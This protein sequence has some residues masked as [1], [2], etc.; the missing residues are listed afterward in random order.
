MNHTAFYNYNGIVRRADNIEKKLKAIDKLLTGL[1]EGELICAKNQGRYKWYIKNSIKSVYLPKC[2]YELARKLALKKYYVARKQDLLNE[3]SAC[4]RY[5]RIA[6]NNY[7]G[8]DKVLQNAEY[9]R[10]INKESIPVQQELI[11]WMNEDFD[12]NCYHDENLIVKASQGK[13]VRSKSEAIIDRILF[14]AGV[15]FRYE[16]RL[17]LAEVSLYPDFTIRHP[18]TG[19]YYYWEH[20]GM[21]DN[22]EYVSGACRKI[23]QY[24]DNGIIPS[25]N[26]ILTY[27][28]KEHPLVIDEVERLIEVY[29]G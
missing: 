10:L 24:C 18:K 20:F 23:K 11:D 15:P 25:V 7:S 28:T 14:R 1:P 9:A 6:E 12:S 22:A 2:N 19:E 4:R 26:L 21:M 3:L 16:C 27:E 13:Y 17:E 29:F 5:I 8:T